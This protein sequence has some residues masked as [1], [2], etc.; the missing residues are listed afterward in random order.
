MMLEGIKK[1]G[2][3]WLFGLT[4]FLI[5]ENDR[6]QG[7]IRY[8]DSLLLEQSARHAKVLG[9][10][11]S[12]PQE[13]IKEVAVIKK[14]EDEGKPLAQS[15]PVDVNRRSASTILSE[16]KRQYN[17]N[18]MNRE[19]REQREFEEAAHERSK[20]VVRP[21]VADKLVEEARKLRKSV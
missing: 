2:L 13:I 18:R 15:Y 10:I 16:V 20:L 4:R 9:E 8:Q 21:S 7:I 17:A 12:R 11:A 19:M 14:D 6:L 3:A 5:S 1:Y